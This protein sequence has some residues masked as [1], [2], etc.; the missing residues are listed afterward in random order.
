MRQPGL[1]IPGPQEH[2]GLGRAPFFL[3]EAGGIARYVFLE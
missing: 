1:E 3:A 2:K